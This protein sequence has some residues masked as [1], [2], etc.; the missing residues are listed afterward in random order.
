MVRLRARV[1]IPRPLRRAG[2]SVIAS[3]LLAGSWPGP[4]GAGQLRGRI[5]DGSSRQPVAGVVLRA[6]SPLGG[7]P[8]HAVSDADGAFHLGGLAHGR[9]EIE[10]RSLAYHP[11]RVSIDV[12]DSTVA[13]EIALAPLPLVMDEVV[14][15]ARQEDGR[16]TAAFVEHLQMSE[17]RTAGIDLPQILELA[18]GVDVRRYGGLGAFSSLS[19]RGSTSEQVLVFLDG[20]PLNQAV[21][22]G[23]DLGSLPVGGIESIDVY[24]GAVPGRFGGNSLGGV[25]HLRTQKP[26]GPAR[27]HL[28]AQAGDFGTRGLSASLSG[29]RRDWDGLALVDYSGSDNDFRFLDDN[30]TPDFNLADDEWA[31]R[32]NSDFT[33]VRVMVRAARHV[34]DSRLQLFHTQDVSHRGVPGIGNFQALHTRFETRRGVSQFNL[35]GP[36][37]DGRAG[38]R[39]KAYRSVEQTDYKDLL[40]EVGVGIQHDR[41]RTTARGLRVEGNVLFGRLLATTFGGVRRER[42]A[43]RHLLQPR[44]SS[45]SSRRLGASAGAE[46]QITELWGRLVVEAG[47]QVE[48]LADDFADAQNAD[49]ALGENRQ[50]LWTSRLGMSLD[51]GGG[52]TAQAH[53]GRYGRPPGFFELFGD[54]GAVIGNTDLV[55]ETGR[56]LDGGFVYRG[57]PSTSGVQLAEVVI[58]DNAVDDMIRFIQNSQRVSQPHNIGSARLRGIEARARGVIAGRL[59]LRG[60]YTRQATENRSPFPYYEG[61]DLPNAPRRR[62]R[63]RFDLDAP[64]VTLHY[65]VSHESRH[66]LD[67]ANLRT[68]PAR[69]VHTVGARVP[70]GDAVTL[71]VEVRNLTDNQVADLWGYPLPGRAAF[72]SLDIDLSLS[73]N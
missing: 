65:E 48:H 5:V 73:G 72:L 51:L 45:P 60:S 38:Y 36:L 40:D 24:R 30:G 3:I 1:A 67:R 14:V 7:A 58:Y 57:A 55:S 6:Q 42:F 61:N 21:G 13:I 26:G 62:L 54:R 63:S 10:T 50:T 19:I 8:V 35:F 22:G 28:R 41:N 12:T 44:S 49:P 29:R 43:P 69:T 31:T 9:W 68:V 25:V 47:L 59:R 32:R 4:A 11:T 16:H 39:L 70:A 27:A 33:A 37:V 18:S 52:W 66:F 17:I 15:Y 20:V 46:A 34:G 56:S 23:I 53:A 64:G 71:A 2:F